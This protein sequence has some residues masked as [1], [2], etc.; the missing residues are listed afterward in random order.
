MEKGSRLSDPFIPEY[1][2]SHQ[3]Y[4]PTVRVAVF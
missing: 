1:S 3:G 2:F 4:I